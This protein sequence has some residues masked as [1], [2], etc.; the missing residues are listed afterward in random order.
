MILIS[1][2]VGKVF[3]G[4]VN[5][6]DGDLIYARRGPGSNERPFLIIPPA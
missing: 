4:F 6:F 1:R 5:R 3:H 2:S